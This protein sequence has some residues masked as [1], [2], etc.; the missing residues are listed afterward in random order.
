MKKHLFFLFTFTFSSFSIHTYISEKSSSLFLGIFS[1]KAL[2]ESKN[3]TQSITYQ[4][5]LEALKKKRTQVIEFERIKAVAKQL[6]IRVW[7]F[8]GTAASFAHYVKWDL[9]RLKGDLQY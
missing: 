9:E 4:E 5:L 1:S 7:L 2:A 3:D 8:G 6:G